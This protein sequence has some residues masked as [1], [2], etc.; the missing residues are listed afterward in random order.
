V[1][2]FVYRPEVE[3]Y[4]WLEDA[5]RYVDVT[6]D[7]IDCSITRKLN[8]VSTASLSLQNRDNRYL[9]LFK[10]M[11]R[12]A[13]WLTRTQRMLAFTGYL[14][15]ATVFAVHP[16]PI[17]IEASCTL[18]LLQNTYFDPGLPFMQQFFAENGHF[19]YDPST[20]NLQD[21]ELRFGNFDSK[22][23]W[24]IALK[25]VLTK[26]GGFPDDHVHITNI[27]QGFLDALAV[28]MKKAVTQDAENFESLLARI[29]KLMNAPTRGSTTTSHSGSDDFGNNNANAATFRRSFKKYA[30][31]LGLNH[32]QQYNAGV[33]W[34]VAKGFKLPDEIAIALIATS[35]AESALEAKAFLDTTGATGLFQLVSSPGGKDWYGPNGWLADAIRLDPDKKN[36]RPNPQPPKLG[37]TTGLT[38]RSSSEPCL[39]HSRLH[40]GEPRQQLSHDQQYSVSG[41]PPRRGRSGADSSCAAAYGAGQAV[42]AD[43]RLLG[44][45][46]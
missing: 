8:A 41:Q 37:G 25:A 9:E 42:R 43:H 6:D 39:Q 32:N 7:I 23:G 1:R 27:P 33:I 20:G 34:G 18:K 36:S 10:P 2:R 16:R 17:K 13:I 21:A 29:E 46:R 24:A 15:E 14:D 35:Y 12:I 26:I 44:A 22:H 40:S 28:E 19:L 31:K 3:A 30:R 45:S 5:Q 38:N 11:D 4:I